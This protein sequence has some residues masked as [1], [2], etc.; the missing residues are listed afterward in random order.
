MRLPHPSN[1]TWYCR[2]PFFFFFLLPFL[3]LSI[4]SSFCKFIYGGCDPLFLFLF[5]HFLYSFLSVMLF[6]FF[7]FSVAASSTLS[8]D[9]RNICTASPLQFPVFSFTFFLFS[10]FFLLPLV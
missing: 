6:F 7:F 2:V 9:C 8:F 1:S 10:F 4:F 5:L 3:L